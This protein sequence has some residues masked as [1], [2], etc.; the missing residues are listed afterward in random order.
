MC[1]KPWVYV[2]FH[3][4]CLD[5]LHRLDLHRGLEVDENLGGVQDSNKASHSCDPQRCSHNPFRS[6]I[7][8]SCR[9]SMSLNVKRNLEGM[10]I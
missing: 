4:E 9:A 1:W 5:I 7:P 3:A 8:P 10:M 2:E 6:P